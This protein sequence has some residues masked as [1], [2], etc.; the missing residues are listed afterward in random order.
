MKMSLDILIKNGHVIDATQCLD[1]AADIGVRSGTISDGIGESKLTIDAS[2]CYVVPGLIDFH[3]HV[4]SKGSELGIPA[5]LM[6]STG[7]TTVVDA[8]SAGWANFESFYLT[9]IAT[10]VCTIKA[11]CNISSSGLFQGGYAEDY[12]THML[13]PDKIAETVLKH[14]ESICGLKLRYS[15]ET[16]KEGDLQPLNDLMKIADDVSL[17]VVIHITDPPIDV[18]EL[19]NRF[20]TGDV[21]CHCYHGSGATI[22]NEHGEILPGVLAARER[23]VLF[24]ASNGMMNFSI[25]VAQQAMQQGFIPDIVSTDLTQFTFNKVGSICSLPFVM[26]KHLALGMSLADIIKATTH[27]PAKFLKLEDKIGSL[28]TGANADVT[29]FKIVNKQIDF[30]DRFGDR[31]TGTQ[32]IVPVMTIKNGQIVFRNSEFLF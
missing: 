20:R 16:V 17:P 13:K 25:K 4:F 6:L 30:I 18:E 11:L 9:E 32:V 21:F 8:G 15:K 26:S 27:T 10:A 19:A 1:G 14:K 29:I 31:M 24:D 22:L 28:K 5:D 2:G 12:S 7:V 3:A 23:G